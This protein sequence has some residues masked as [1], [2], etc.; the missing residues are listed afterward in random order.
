MT[1]YFPLFDPFP[2]FLKPA[3]NWSQFSP[4]S[5]FESAFGVRG[6]RAFWCSRK[7][8]SFFFLN[9]NIVKTEAYF[10]SQS[11][12]ASSI[13]TFQPACGCH[14]PAVSDSPGA[15]V[16]AASPEWAFLRSTYLTGK[17]SVVLGQWSIHRNLRSVADHFQTWVAS[18]FLDTPFQPWRSIFKV[19]TL[20]CVFSCS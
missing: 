20:L 2:P 13:C 19:S 17:E 6:M 1:N 11:Q 14:L 3:I 18:C 12:W 5:S 4:H 10:K 9:L 8:E 16:F 15:F 7:N